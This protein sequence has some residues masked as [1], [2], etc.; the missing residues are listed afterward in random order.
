MKSYLKFVNSII[1]ISM[2]S[3]F[4]DQSK[5]EIP[6]YESQKCFQISFILYNQN[7]NNKALIS[8]SRQRDLILLAL[9]CRETVGK[10]EEERERKKINSDDIPFITK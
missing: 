4:C 8:E 1:F 2:L 3:L 7:Q 9:I 5:E 6:N 10:R